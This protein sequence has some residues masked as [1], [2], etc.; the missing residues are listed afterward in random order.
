MCVLAAG[1][2][3]LKR[4]VCLARHVLRIVVAVFVFVRHNER[5]LMTFFAAYFCAAIEK[6]AASCS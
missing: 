4:F 2:M 3:S 6:Y 1:Q 5:G